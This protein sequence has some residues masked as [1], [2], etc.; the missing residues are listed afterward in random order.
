L[1]LRGE[2]QEICYTRNSY[3]EIGGGE[4]GKEDYEKMEVR[5]IL[6]AAAIQIY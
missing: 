5:R 6:A 3:T 4:V 2:E 1:E